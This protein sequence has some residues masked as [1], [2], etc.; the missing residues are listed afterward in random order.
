MGA[1]KNVIFD[2]QEDI[3]AGELTFL[4][5][6]TKYGITINEVDEIACDLRD[7]FSYDDEYSQVDHL[8]EDV[9]FEAQYY[10]QRDY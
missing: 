3:E 6:A 9:L 1:T 8:Y 7:Q 4:Q 10:D 2:I 5:I